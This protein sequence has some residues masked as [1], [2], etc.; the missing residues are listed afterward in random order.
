MANRHSVDYFLDERRR[1]PQAEDTPDFLDLT[2]SLV[3]RTYNRLARGLES[4]GRTFLISMRL[5]P[6]ASVES[7]KNSLYDSSRLENSFEKGASTPATGSR[8]RSHRLSGAGSYHSL[9]ER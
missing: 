7:F 5:D 3:H 2:F 1:I 4:S 8:R 9:R 6:D